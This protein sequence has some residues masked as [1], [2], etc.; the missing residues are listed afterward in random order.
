[1]VSSSLDAQT[2]TAG[3]T[4]TTK[5]RKS[6]KLQNPTDFSLPK[7]NKNVPKGELEGNSLVS[8]AAEHGGVAELPKRSQ[9]LKLGLN[10]DGNEK[11]ETRRGKNEAGRPPRGT[12][13]KGAN[14]HQF[15]RAFQ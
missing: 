14:G 12:T 9:S 7:R 5:K 3:Q 13:K 6:Q 11:I 4:K 8:V 1:M 15:G 10:H 2:D